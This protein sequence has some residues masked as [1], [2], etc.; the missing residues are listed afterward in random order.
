M[1]QSLS[2]HSHS[3]WFPD[4]HLSYCPSAIAQ[5]HVVGD[6]TTECMA[7][8]FLMYAESADQTER[9]TD[10]QTDRQVD[11]QTDR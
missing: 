1:V 11:R 6:H 3:V 4:V 5:H 8:E 7:V 2:I 10:R 9:Q